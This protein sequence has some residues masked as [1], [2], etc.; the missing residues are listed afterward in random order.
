M[1][2]LSLRRSNRIASKSTSNRS[3]PKVKRSFG[4]ENPKKYNGKESTGEI[5]F[6][7]QA[8]PKTPARFPVLEPR[9][10]KKSEV[11]STS[12]FS[13]NSRSK[14]N[15]GT[16]FD[17]TV[18]TSSKYFFPMM[19]RGRKRILES[20]TADNI[21]VILIN[22]TSKSSILIDVN[23]GEIGEMKSLERVSA[24]NYSISSQ[25][26]TS[27]R[28]SE[29]VAVKNETTVSSSHAIIGKKTNSSNETHTYKN[30]LEQLMTYKKNEIVMAKMT[31]HMI[32]PAKVFFLLFICIFFEIIFSNCIRQ[33]FQKF[34]FNFFSR[35]WTLIRHQL[36]STFMEIT[37]PGKYSNRS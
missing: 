6:V 11:P 27:L 10:A 29:R 37:Q 18:P 36:M 12:I 4:R 7:A 28:R 19:T 24:E 22:P 1:E 8:K 2:S 30:A 23:V 5:S 33:I 20:P 9:K 34:V 15:I 3:S 17:G 21:E 31:G 13:S 32:W 26:K 16:A 25:P 14:S 35:F